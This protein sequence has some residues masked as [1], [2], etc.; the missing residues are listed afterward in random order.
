MY[1]F[2]YKTCV[3]HLAHDIL[4]PLLPYRKEVNMSLFDKILEKLGLKRGKP[5]ES[6][7]TA[8]GGRK[9]APTTT[10]ARPGPA[11]PAPTAPIAISEVDV[12]KKLETLAA[13]KPMKLNWRTSI[14]DLL[15][16]LGIENSYEARK[17]LAT[18]LGCPPELMRDSAKMNTWLHKKVMQEIAANGGNIPKELLD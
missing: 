8:S 2:K 17:E 5:A 7:G 15:Y 16:L 13:S 14:A 4:I 1:D 9:P 18:E 6:T 12:V 3:N 11:A 10:P